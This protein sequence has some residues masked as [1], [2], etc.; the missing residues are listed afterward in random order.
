VNAPETYPFGERQYTARD[1]AGHVWTFTQTVANVEPGAWG[2][3]MV[4]SA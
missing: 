4:E 2:G 3:E 1:F